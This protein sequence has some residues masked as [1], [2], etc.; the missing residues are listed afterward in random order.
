VPSPKRKIRRS[1][2]AAGSKS[3]VFPVN[4]DESCWGFRRGSSSARASLAGTKAKRSY[5]YRRRRV[6][7]ATQ[8]ERTENRR[9]EH[10]L[11]KELRS[12]TM[13]GNI[14]GNARGMA[15]KAEADTSMQR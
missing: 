7:T 3:L 13:E 8:K 4:S 12:N 1:D 9:E 10:V 11:P 5:E 15:K 2:I 14:G 6:Y